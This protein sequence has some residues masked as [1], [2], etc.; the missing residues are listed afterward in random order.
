MF[1][2]QKKKK[3][4]LL[5]DIMFNFIVYPFNAFLGIFICLKCD[6]MSLIWVLGKYKE[7]FINSVANATKHNIKKNWKLLQLNLKLVKV[8]DDCHY[9]NVVAL[10]D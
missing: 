3:I 9:A 7:T 5:P 4:R 1:Y 2:T 10:N 6:F 8:S